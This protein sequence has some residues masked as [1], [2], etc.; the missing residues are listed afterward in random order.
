MYVV[1]MRVGETKESYQLKQQLAYEGRER[2]A[3]HEKFRDPIVQS[4]RGKIGGARQSPAQL[5]HQEKNGK[6]LG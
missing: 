2:N 3:V 1:Y 6:E 5:A 4:L